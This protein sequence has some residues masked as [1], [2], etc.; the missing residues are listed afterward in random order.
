MRLHNGWYKV[1]LDNIAL[2]IRAVQNS[3]SKLVRCY[4]GIYLAFAFLF[5]FLFLVPESAIRVG[6]NIMYNWPKL[7]ENIF[8]L[9]SR[10]FNKKTS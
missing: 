7:L 3:T 6:I 10:V 8:I 5:S 1:L 2:G 9:G 4:I